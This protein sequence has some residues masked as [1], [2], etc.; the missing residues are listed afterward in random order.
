M[1][2]AP[3]P[4]TLAVLTMEPVARS[5][6]WLVA[7]EPQIEELVLALDASR[8]SILDQPDAEHTMMFSRAKLESCRNAFAAMIRRGE[9]KLHKLCELLGE[10]FLGEAFDLDS[11]VV[12]EVPT[13]R[14]RFTLSHRISATDL[15]S[16]TDL[17][18]GSRQLRRFRV[19]DG[20][21]LQTPM[22]VA[23]VVEYQPRT[24]GRFA[25]HKL[26]SRIK[27]EEEIW[28]KVVDEIFGLDTLVNRDKQLRELSRFVK[29]VFGIKFVVDEAADVLRLQE[30]LADLRMQDS[31]L[32]RYDVPSLDATRR[33]GLVEVKSYMDDEK[34]RS[35]WGAMKSVV[36]WWDKLF[37]IQ[38]LTLATHHNERETLTRESH[39]GHKSRRE[40]VRD[41]VAER[42][43]LFKFYRDLLRWLFIAAPDEAAPTFPKVAIVVNA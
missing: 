26:V 9:A 38:I 2:C 4:A 33:L 12:G 3:T 17:D 39:T 29:D 1:G 5:P 42:I 18:L 27:A 10:R 21:R 20:A 23:N 22:L 34:K 36:S 28:N 30:A 24:M 37:E 6:L 13:T 35:G 8:Q 25:V 16:Y 19:H 7:E 41:T 14:E 31:D 15:Y 11:I 43:P 32:D 40:S